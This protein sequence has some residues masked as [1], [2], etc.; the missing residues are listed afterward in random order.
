MWVR[1]RDPYQP[2]REIRIKYVTTGAEVIL[3]DF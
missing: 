3:Q 1:L 2:T